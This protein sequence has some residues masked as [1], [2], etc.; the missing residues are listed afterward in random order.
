[1]LEDKKGC[2]ST[3]ASVKDQNFSVCE[4]G[5]RV[6]WAK[7]SLVIPGLGTVTGKHF[8][9]DVLSFSGCEISVNSLAPGESIPFSH[10]HQANEEIYIFV[11]GHGQML[12]DSEVVDIKEGSVVRVSPSAERTWRNN[13]IEPLQYIVIQVQENSLQQYSSS[14]GLVTQ[15]NPKWPN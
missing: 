15:Q 9:K 4:T 1:M 7:H 6:D 13:S 10:R 11:S 2:C 8:L 3:S 14:D 12:I 5:T